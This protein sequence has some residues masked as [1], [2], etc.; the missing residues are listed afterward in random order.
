MIGCAS[1][2][3]AELDARSMA[4]PRGERRLQ[5]AGVDDRPVDAQ[6]DVAVAWWARRSRSTRRSRRPSPTRAPAARARRARRTARGRPRASA[7]GRRRRPRRADRAS[8]SAASSSVTRP[9]WPTLPSSVATRA[10]ASSAAPAAWA[11]SRNPSS[12]GG[13]A[14]PSSSSCQMASGA[15]PTPP[16][17]SSGRRPSRGAAKP[18]PSGPT[19]GSS[20]PGA[21]SHRRCGPGADVLDE[22]V[23]LVAA[24]RRA[25]HAEGA[26]QERPLVRASSPPLGRPQHVE[27]AG[28]RAAGRRVGAAQDGVGAVA[29]GGHDAPPGAPNGACTRSATAAVTAR[30][31]PG[32]RRR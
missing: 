27:L 17:T 10:S 14:P 21:S 12:T 30:A 31:V 20:S 25:Q 4:R 22:E 13:G 7:A 6:A 29:L 32:R 2:M 11:A 19:S 16:P 5:R 15:M 26:R 28:L 1:S 18:I 3:P 9:W 23:Q 8:S 24:G